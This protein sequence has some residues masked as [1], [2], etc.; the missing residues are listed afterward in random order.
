MTQFHVKATGRDSTSTQRNGMQTYTNVL[1][2][3]DC[4]VLCTKNPLCQSFTF[5]S[6]SKICQ[7]ANIPFA[8]ASATAITVSNTIEWFDRIE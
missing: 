3:F 8:L 4:G 1:S 5:S 2:S 6:T 7:L